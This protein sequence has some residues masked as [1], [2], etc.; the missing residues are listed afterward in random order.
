MRM[1]RHKELQTEGFC[2]LVKSKDRKTYGFLEE[3][4]SD[5]EPPELYWRWTN[6]TKNRDFRG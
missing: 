5:Y 4:L 6:E 3:D 2:I 1:Q